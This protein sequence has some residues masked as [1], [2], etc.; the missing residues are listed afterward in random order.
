MKT[1]RTKFDELIELD[2]YFHFCYGYFLWFWHQ[3]SNLKVAR[4]MLYPP[5]SHNPMKW[6]TITLTSYCVDWTFIE[7]L[8][9]Y[10]YIVYLNIFLFLRGSHI[11]IILFI[12]KF[13]LFYKVL[14][15]NSIHKFSRLELFQFFLRWSVLLMLKLVF[16]L[17]SI[18]LFFL[19]LFGR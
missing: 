14:S 7:Q 8:L 11:R 4:F 16:F 18:F 1:W 13:F 9:V 2:L 10:I 12:Y 19:I 15:L 17:N 6:W 5:L 3:F